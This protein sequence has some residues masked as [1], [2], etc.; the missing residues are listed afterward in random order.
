MEKLFDIAHGDDFLH[1]TPKAQATKA[2]LKNVTTSNSKSSAQQR[3][4]SQ[5]A[6]ANYEMGKKH[7]WTTYLIKG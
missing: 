3:E 1:V 4:Q 5:N 2:K 7:L 6:K